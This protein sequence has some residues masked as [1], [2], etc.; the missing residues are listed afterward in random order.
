MNKEEY[1]EELERKK[2]THKTKKEERKK[3]LRDRKGKGM[4]GIGKKMR[5]GEKNSRESVDIGANFY[6]CKQA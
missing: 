4:T 6:Q 1:D 5:Q 2:R 3:G